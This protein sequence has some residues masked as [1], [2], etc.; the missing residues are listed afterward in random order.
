M[1]TR[2]LARLMDWASAVASLVGWWM[3]RLAGCAGRGGVREGGKGIGAAWGVGSGGGCGW[4]RVRESQEAKPRKS[5]H[6]S[7]GGDSAGGEH[8]ARRLR[9]RRKRP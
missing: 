1:T 3:G 9:C 8:G 5:R 2:C 7:F 4:R 6:A